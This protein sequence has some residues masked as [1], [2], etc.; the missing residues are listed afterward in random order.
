MHPYYAMLSG[1]EP[2]TQIATLWYV[3]HR[4]ELPLPPDMVKR[5]KMHYYSEIISDGSSFETETA[6]QTL[7]SIYYVPA[8]SLGYEQAPPTNTGVVVR[9]SLIYLPRQP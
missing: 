6:L 5:I 7:L 1:K 2:S 9:P 3:R 4:G 8:Q